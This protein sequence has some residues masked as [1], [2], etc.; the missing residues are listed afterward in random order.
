[1]L[2]E[3]SQT[4][5]DKHCVVPLIRRILKKKKQVKLIETDRG[6]VAARG[7]GRGGQAVS[8]ACPGRVGLSMA[9]WPFWPAPLFWALLHRVLGL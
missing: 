6:L 1:M 4:E 8:S 5:K 7:P 2:R 9:G 3:I